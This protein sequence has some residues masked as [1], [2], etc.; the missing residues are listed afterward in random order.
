MSEKQLP[1]SSEKLASVESHE[2]AKQLEKAAEHLRQRAEQEAVSR[3]T[4]EQEKQAVRTEAQKEAISGRERSNGSE[5][6]QQAQVHRSVKQQTYRATM[7]RVEAKL[8]AY[9]RT[10]SRFVNNANVDKISN[11][12]ARTV[13][14][15][16]GV[17]GSGVVAVVVMIAVTY[18]AHT[19]G[20]TV[21]SSVFVVALLIGWIIG[22]MCEAV[23]RMIK[24]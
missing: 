16:S 24:R 18:Y 14:R 15:P 9:Q 21:S 19:L 6:H 3:E 17:L 10:F 5:R 11:V 23:W 1:N 22:L 2:A 7:R 8:P 20:F 13:A 4:V 12:T